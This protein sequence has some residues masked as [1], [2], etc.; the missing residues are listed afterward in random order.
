MQRQRKVNTLTQIPPSKRPDDAAEVEILNLNF[1]E[2]SIIIILLGVRDDAGKVQTLS[3][4]QHKMRSQRA[5]DKQ[6][7][8][9]KRKNQLEIKED[10]G[11]HG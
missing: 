1:M 9:E 11:R 10:I 7:L 6:N 3:K 4:T 5:M 2:F 8:N